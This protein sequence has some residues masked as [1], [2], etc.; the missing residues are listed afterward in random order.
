M[1]R[2]VRAVY[3]RGVLRPITPLNGLVEGQAVSLLVREEITDPEEITRREEELDHCLEAEGAQ[4]RFPAPDQ[5]PDPA[6][7]PVV[8]TGEPL[9]ETIIRERR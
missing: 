7:R 1:D 9:S 6:F 2:V 5:L 4:L 8:V 3:E